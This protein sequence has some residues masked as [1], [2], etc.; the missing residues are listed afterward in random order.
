MGLVSFSLVM[1]GADLMLIG[2]SEC[3]KAKDLLVRLV[4]RVRSAST[5]A[6]A[7]P[8]TTFTAADARRT[9]VSADFSPGPR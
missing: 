1:M 6:S 8:I 5:P 4:A 7:A 2:D 9:D 3:A